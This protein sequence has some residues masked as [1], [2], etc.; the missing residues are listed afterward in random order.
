MIG[1]FP[2]RSDEV[3]E[4]LASFRKHWHGFR[5]DWRTFRN[6]WMRSRDDW[7]TS[8]TIGG[9]SGAIGG[10][11]EALDEFP[12]RLA[13]FR[14]DWRTFR[15]DWQA[16]GT[17]GKRASSN[18]AFTARAAATPSRPAP[19]PLSSRGWPWHPCRFSCGPAQ[20]PC[21]CACRWFRPALSTPCARGRLP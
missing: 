19:T 18:L 6:D 9:V 12:E 10:L 4:R 16:S 1:R 3:P 14:D 5:D 15:D 21:P 11:P 2:G 13:G 7:P 20:T 8:G 17:I